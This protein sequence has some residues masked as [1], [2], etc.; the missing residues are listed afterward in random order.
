MLTSLPF[1]LYH[2]EQY[3]IRRYSPLLA[4]FVE[5]TVDKF[6][7]ECGFRFSDIFASIGSKLKSPV[8]IHQIDDIKQ[9]DFNDFVSQFASEMDVIGKQFLPEKYENDYSYDTS[10]GPFPN[11]LIPNLTPD[12]NEARYPPWYRLFI[13]RLFRSLLFCDF[14]F[15]DLPI[16]IVYVVD[17]GHSC[18]NPDEIRQKLTKVPEW[19]KEF[20]KDIPVV[21][22]VVGD[23]LN[24]PVDLSHLVQ[25]RKGG[26]SYVTSMNFR[27]KQGSDVA[28]SLK[29]YFG[30]D[31]NIMNNP[32][33][34][35]NFTLDDVAAIEKVHNDIF[36][37]FLN[38]EVARL[39]KFFENESE[40]KNK[41]SKTIQS[42]F[43]KKRE[44]EEVTQYLKI[45][46]KK[47]V[48][49]Q[50]AS[51][52]M[53]IG[54]YAAAQRSYKYFLSSLYQDEYPLIQNR[55]QG[56]ILLCTLMTNDDFD[57]YIDDAKEAIDNHLHTESLRGALI[58][59][60][61]SVEFACH[62]QKW[63]I[64]LEFCHKTIQ[65]IQELYTDN[66]YTR[67][68][69]TAII[70]ERVVGLET[71]PKHQIAFRTLAAFDYRKCHQN[72]HALRCFLWLLKTMPKTMW[73][74]LW[75]ILAIEKVILLSEQQQNNRSLHD[76][77]HLMSITDMSVDLQNLLLTQFLSIFTDRTA[78][79]KSFSI[80][81]KPLLS[82][83]KVRLYDPSQPEYYGFG[84]N[85]FKKMLDKY[86]LWYSA[87]VSRSGS[88]SFE[89]IWGL[90]NNNVDENRIVS[91]DNAVSIDIV[92]Y[93]K[94]A[95]TI[96]VNESK[97]NIVYDP[98]V[99]RRA[100][101]VSDS[102]LI[103][104]NLT[105][106]SSSQ[107]PI[108]DLADTTAITSGS[109]TDET[110]SI[111]SETITSSEA[112]LRTTTLTPS[113]PKSK[114]SVDLIDEYCSQTLISHLDIHGSTQKSNKEK[115]SINIIPHK[116]G[117]FTINKLSNNYWGY[118][119]NDVDFKPV[120]FFA[121]TDFPQLTMNVIGLAKI[122]ESNQCI[123]FSLKI[124]NKGNA[125]IYKYRILCD[126]F[127]VYEQGKT[128]FNKH[129][130]IVTINRSLKPKKAVNIPFIFRVPNDDQLEPVLRFVIDVD[131]HKVA[132][133]KLKLT[134]EKKVN[135]SIK[136]LPM[137]NDTFSKLLRVQF[138]TEKGSFISAFRKDG[139]ILKSLSNNHINGQD[140]AT[141]N[142]VV[143]TTLDHTDGTVEE[144]WRYRLLQE[145]EIGILYQLPNCRYLAQANVKIP[146]IEEEKKKKESGQIHFKLQVDEKKSL[147]I[148]K[149][150]DY[151]G[152][153]LFIEPLP[154]TSDMHISNPI[155]CCS[156]IGKKRQLIGKNIDAVFKF[157][158][159][160]KVIAKISGF[161]VS[162]K[163]DFSNPKLIKLIQ[164][165]EL[166]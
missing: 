111:E 89:D 26:F 101:D 114:S 4:L 10:V 17:Y 36:K 87:N 1:R 69:L 97:L 116:E 82:V 158:T 133:E 51:Y 9:H 38:Q 152:K 62:K 70:Y 143:F 142:H 60:L 98:N 155:N 66:Q 22:L 43:S 81:L 27:S 68:L 18:L 39:Q 72:G 99:S 149:L 157:V 19:M 84:K 56:S 100:S 76:I 6:V 156:W 105:P 137:Q 44:P 135:F 30:W 129:V 118:V 130:Q 144:E 134:I 41:F 3:V 25:Y 103:H 92:L 78:D 91:V 12:S 54:D 139:S 50:H 71:R 106:K 52:S 48:Y 23:G 166:K 138:E 31:K 58:I 120:S 57:V 64:A 104:T 165:F 117:R 61:L 160:Q 147:C 90:S 109:S 140:I 55:V 96:H 11:L 5:P 162:E 24:N 73:S 108:L 115:L 7:S 74:I 122:V 124:E 161:H 136:N 75:Q 159:N 8:R 94:H 16:G 153:K 86:Q 2:P 77:A 150:I 164:T 102:Y 145:N 148:V 14:A 95:F 65:R 45:P 53:M 107:H 126:P 127:I 123:P 85:D 32:N 80:E 42:W 125:T 154:I 29:Y 37:H 79:L 132:Y 146:L 163:R 47:I 83:K 151:E 63:D 28:E 34:G 119:N 112:S 35:K 113:T 21:C 49:L 110:T 141:K 121:Y 88:I 67:S 13:F 15:H 20:L 59:P 128:A 93:N 46:V 131:G 40:Q 33:L